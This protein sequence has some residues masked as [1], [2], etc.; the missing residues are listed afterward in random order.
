[1]S[2]QQQSGQKQIAIM[3][4]NEIGIL[5]YHTMSGGRSDAVTPLLDSDGRPLNSWRDGQN[6]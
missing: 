2:D 3:R 4:D 6:K 1:M 5:Y